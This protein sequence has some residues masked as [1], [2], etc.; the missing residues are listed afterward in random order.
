MHH[1]EQKNC[2]RCG[3]AF[4]SAEQFCRKCG[5]TLV[6]T[7]DVNASEPHFKKGDFIG[8]K[9]EWYKTLGRGGFG[10]VYLV[11]SHE[12][13][14][15]LALKTFRDKYLADPKVRSQFEAEAQVWVQLERHPYIVR[16]YFVEKVAGRLNVGME[17]VAPNPENIN[18]LE[19]Y[20][21]R[22]SVDLA[23]TLRWA[24]QCCYGMEHAHSY[25]RAHRDLKPGNILIGLDNAV[26]ITDFGLAGV[27][28]LDGP[29]GTRPYMPPE[30]FID[31]AS[32]DKRSDIYSFGVVLYQMATGEVPF[33]AGSFTEFYELHCYA[34]VPTIDSPLFP[35]IQRCMEKEPDKRYQ[36]FGELRSDLERL[37][38][39][40]TGESLSP[41]ELSDLEAWEWNNKAVTLNNLGR[42]TEALECSKRALEMFPSFASVWVNKGTSL[43]SLERHEEA[44]R[45]YDTALV[46]DP[47]NVNAISGKGLCFDCLGRYAEALECDDHA[48]KINPTRVDVWDNKGLTLDSLGRCAEAI[49]CFNKALERDS[50]FINAW[51]N[52]ARCLSILG[53]PKKAIACIDQALAIDPL[54]VDAWT[55][56]GADLIMLGLFDEAIECFDQAL[57]IDPQNARA[58]WG[59][60]EALACVKQH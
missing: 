28:E 5:V 59:K 25:I 23:Q 44:I 55:G 49:T 18:S 48:L 50:R 16:A 7:P 6:L 26:K 42:Y 60:E 45:C 47:Q 37:I 22:G 4:S 30:Q 14:S 40:E 56:K 52:K 29:V 53:E 17:Y 34:P 58:Q 36:S 20:L 9:Y 1:G 43:K 57:E 13:N 10:I 33:T 27:I 8:H 24:I 41:P 15:P 35:V 3:T 11:V 39:Q 31:A 21:R 2:V 46:I 38:K 51:Y 19:G 54:Y 32:C 12:L